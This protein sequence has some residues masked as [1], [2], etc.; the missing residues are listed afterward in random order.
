M[1]I[2]FN[3]RKAI[4]NPFYLRVRAGD[5]DMDASINSAENRAVF[6]ALLCSL[7]TAQG[8]HKKKIFSA[9]DSHSEVSSGTI[10]V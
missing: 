2:S 5:S 9:R 1:G 10:L 8:L 4:K 7:Y 6:L 3:S